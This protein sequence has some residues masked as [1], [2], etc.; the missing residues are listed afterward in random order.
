MQV[1]EGLKTFRVNKW[2]AW[3]LE[4]VDG[5]DDK[6]F[7]EPC[8]EGHCR[9]NVRLGEQGGMVATFYRLISKFSGR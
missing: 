4:S 2:Q 1:S 9:L 5:D 8:S 7:V 3:R 6:V